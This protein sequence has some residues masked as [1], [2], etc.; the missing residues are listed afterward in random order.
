M[1]PVERLE[2]TSIRCILAMS[3]EGLREHVRPGCQGHSLGGVLNLALDGVHAG[4]LQ[5]LHGELLR[6]VVLFGRVETELLGH[7]VGEHPH[8]ILLQVLA[9]IT[10]HEHG[11]GTADESGC[12]V[13][14]FRS[15]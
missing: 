12:G 14:Q 10:P 1:L 8:R 2:R 9:R 7:L 15:E 5:V 6:T 4:I 3:G 11:A 13:H